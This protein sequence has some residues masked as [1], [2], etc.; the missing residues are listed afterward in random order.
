MDCVQKLPALVVV[1][2]P[3]THWVVGQ[4][5]THSSVDCTLGLFLMVDSVYVNLA[6][7]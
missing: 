5:W 4:D 7:P 3:D 1:P 6:D 2:L